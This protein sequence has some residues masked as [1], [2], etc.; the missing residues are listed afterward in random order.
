[1]LIQ[2]MSF[3]SDQ[4]DNLSYLVIDEVSSDAVIVDPTFNIA[5]L[6][7]YLTE[8][9]LNLSAVWLTH[10][11]FDHIS[12]LN[13]VLNFYPDCSV[14]IHQSS[15][16]KF[17]D[18]QQIK[19]LKDGDY[20]SLGESNW[21]VIHTPGHSPDGVCFYLAPHM[22]TG[23]TL[24]VDRCGR[25]DLGDSNVYQLYQSLQRLKEFSKDTI[26]YPGHHYGES[27]TDTI[28]NQRLKNPYLLAV[29]ESEFIRLRMGR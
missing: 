13:D 17:H 23:D 16:H 29:D 1:M 25:A 26:I 8:Y 15:I 11:H 27:K 10:A 2:V 3:L 24:F 5:D 4:M 9:Q 14:Y 7:Q 19:P 12:G 20:V 6:L 22:I 28:G 18:I 21:L